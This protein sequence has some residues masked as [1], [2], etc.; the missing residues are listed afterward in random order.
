MFLYFILTCCHVRF[1]HSGCCGLRERNVTFAAW[2]FQFYVFLNKIFIDD[3]FTNLVHEHELSSLYLA[4]NRFAITCQPFSLILLIAVV[5]PFFIIISLTSFYVSSRIVCSEAVN[6]A[7]LSFA[8]D[9]ATVTP[10][11][12]CL[13]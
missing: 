10:C 8:V 7:A 1:Y 6:I 2:R 9:F 12:L 13:T 5:L 3:L 11:D 4:F